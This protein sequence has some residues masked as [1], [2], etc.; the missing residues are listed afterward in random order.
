MNSDSIPCSGCKKLFKSQGWL[1]NDYYKISGY[2]CSNCY[3]KISHDSYGRPE[4]P[5]D[6]LLMLIKHGVKQ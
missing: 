3:D 4:R 5:N 2:F 1:C 6:Y